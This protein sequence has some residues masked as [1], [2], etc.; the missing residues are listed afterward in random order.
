[1][2]EARDAVLEFDRDPRLARHAGKEA[3][4]DAGAEGEHVGHVRSRRFG[5][6]AFGLAEALHLLRLGV[7][8]LHHRLA[9]AFREEFR[10][11][12]ADREIGADEQLVLPLPQFIRGEGDV[13]QVAASGAGPVRGVEVIGEAGDDGPFDRAYLFPIPD[14]VGGGVDPAFHRGFIQKLGVPVGD[15]ADVFLGQFFRVAFDAFAF[16]DVVRARPDL[17]AGIGGGPAHL[18]PGFED[19]HGA[20]P[21]GKAKRGGEAGKAPAHN[22]GGFT[23]FGMGLVHTG[24]PENIPQHAGFRPPARKRGRRWSIASRRGARG[25]VRRFR[26]AWPKCCSSRTSR[27]NPRRADRRRRASVSSIRAPRHIRGPARSRG[28]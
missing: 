13:G 17:T 9:A 3:G 7:L 10:V 14:R 11:I 15:G 12:G 8:I 28:T 1:M 21:L 22:D 25:R 23:V 20:A 6:A 26:N 19:G 27:D 24:F 5:V 2:L 16:S 4:D 18:F